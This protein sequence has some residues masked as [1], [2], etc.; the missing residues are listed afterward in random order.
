MVYCSCS[1]TAT[2]YSETRL[3]CGITTGLCIGLGRL[4]ACCSLCPRGPSRLCVGS[5]TGHPSVCLGG[6]LARRLLSAL[7]ASGS[8]LSG[9]PQSSLPTSTPQFSLLLSLLQRCFGSAVG[10]GFRSRL[11]SNGLSTLLL[12]PFNRDPVSPS[13]RALSQCCPKP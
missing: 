9:L 7:V 1:I 4:K 6:L 12:A 10:Q 13:Q 5:G 2:N 11:T 3:R 8:V